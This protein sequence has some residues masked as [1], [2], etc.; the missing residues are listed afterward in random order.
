MASVQPFAVA[1]R[2]SRTRHGKTNMPLR[3]NARADDSMGPYSSSSGPNGIWSLKS[4]FSSTG[5]AAFLAF[6]GPFGLRM[7]MPSVALARNAQIFGYWVA[8]GVDDR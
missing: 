7:R 1:G 5:A 6:S 4:S 3:A 8:I 2:L